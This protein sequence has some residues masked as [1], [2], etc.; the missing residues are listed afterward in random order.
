V[1]VVGPWRAGEGGNE[2]DG[3]LARKPR[4]DALPK[5]PWWGGGGWERATGV[6]AHR[7][8][9]ADVPVRVGGQPGIDEEG[10]GRRCG[11]KGRSGA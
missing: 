8:G 5:L 9:S 7:G 4:G 2:G 3:E 10:S 1:G 6:G 11:A